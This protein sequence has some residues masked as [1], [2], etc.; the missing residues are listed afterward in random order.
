MTWQ[1]CVTLGSK[2]DLLNMKK[3]SDV[4]GKRYPLFDLAWAEILRA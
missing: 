4:F 2:N 3:H 1:S